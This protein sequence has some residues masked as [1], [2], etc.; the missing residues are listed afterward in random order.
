[1]ADSSSSNQAQTGAFPKRLAFPA[2]IAILAIVL[3]RQFGNDTLGYADADRLL[4]DGVFLL[5]LI[6]D[7]GFIDPYNY[8]V[9]YY[10]QYPGLSVGY[11]PIFLPTIEALSNAV[12]GNSMQS[13][14]IALFLFALV[15]FGSWYKLIESYFDTSTA[16]WS[17]VLLI[18]TPIIAKWGWYTMTELPTLSMALLTGALFTKYVNTDKPGYL[19]ATGIALGLACWTKQV[20]IFVAVWLLLHAL[21]IGKL[22]IY[23]MRREAWLTIIISLIILIPL[24]II[25][26]WLGELNMA[27]SVGKAMRLQ[28]DVSL[29]DAFVAYVWKPFP[30]LISSGATVPVLILSML[31][32]LMAAIKRDGRI[33]FAL[34]LMLSTY[35]L[36][37]LYLGI[38]RP[39]DWIY[40]IP[41]FTFF[42]VVPFHYLRPLLGTSAH[43]WL[44]LTVLLGISIYQ[45]TLVY[46]MPQNYATGFQQAAKYVLQNTQSQTVF[47]DGYNNGYFTYFMRINDPDRSMYVL[48]GDKLLSSSGMY[49][50]KGRQIDLKIRVQKKQEIR[51]L[52]QRYGVQYVVVE[53]KNYIGL[54]I[55]EVLRNYLRG[56]EFRLATAIPIRTN[57]S[58]LKSREILVYEFLR[59][60]EP[61]SGVL[62]IDVPI[63]GKTIRVPFRKN[64]KA[65]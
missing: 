34:T 31:G 23:L 20:A 24:A 46:S 17:S 37:G 35:I 21:F 40:W 11:K 27:Q 25:T 48:R 28:K 26:L 47:Y 18:T 59:P 33:I 45:I 14:R 32:L 6:K 13:G 56:D 4:L 51:E 64:L 3:L 22:H 41:A 57:R 38:A 65:E 29:L 1:M 49:A 30:T 62:E 52:F 15:G 36:F 9:N 55:H 39:R 63:V 61:E 60:K 42:A 5:D 50:G 44:S 16:F 10:A 7:L 53:S 54:E 58:G 12:F 8:T 19:I 2:V 43:R